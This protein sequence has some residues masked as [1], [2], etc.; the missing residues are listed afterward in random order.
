MIMIQLFVQLYR[1]YT[2]SFKT[3]KVGELSQ[4]ELLGPHS[5]LECAYDRHK[6]SYKEITCPN[7][8][9]KEK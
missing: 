7:W 9:V 2:N 1:D 6:N 3:S 4:V 8:T 5:S